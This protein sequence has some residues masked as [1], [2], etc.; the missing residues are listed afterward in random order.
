[1]G[2]KT[3]DLSVWIVDDHGH[4]RETLEELIASQPDMKC[5]ASMASC[6]RLLD[7]IQAFTHPDVVLMDMNFKGRMSGKECIRAL[8]AKH[9]DIKVLVLSMYREADLVIDALRSGAY[10]YLYKLDETQDI[11]QGIRDFYEQ[12]MIPPPP[13]IASPMLD[14]FNSYQAFHLSQEETQLLEYI[15]QGQPY[16]QL[17]EQMHVAPS[18]VNDILVTIYEKL[19]QV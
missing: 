12:G 10:G 1:M 2:T 13:P 6:E 9:P 4:F 8:R 18:T 3:Q 19:H 15:I 5:T 16:D 14:L 7:Q 11:I 17:A